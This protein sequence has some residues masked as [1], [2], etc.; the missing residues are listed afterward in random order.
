MKYCI[1]TM[2]QEVLSVFH[3]DLHAMT[4]FSLTWHIMVR[5]PVYYFH[6]NV[7]HNILSNVHTN[8]R[9]YVVTWL[10]HSRESNRRYPDQ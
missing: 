7:W 5:V 3:E 10:K 6:A 2:F 8:V 9:K 1:M 4:I